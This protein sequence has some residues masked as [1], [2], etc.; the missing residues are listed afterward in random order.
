MSV[1]IA[2][3][4]PACGHATEGRLRP[5][6]PSCGHIVY[7][8]PK[9]AAITFIM[10][11]DKVLLVQRG[12]EPGMGLWAL[13][14]GYVDYDEHPAEAAMR[15]TYEETGLRIAVERVLDVFHHVKDGGVI[16]IAFAAGL[17]GGELCAGDDAQQIGWFS[18]DDLPELV[19]TSTISLVSRWVTGE[20]R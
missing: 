9:V 7:F 10:Q 15:E 16:T 1:Y 3:Y 8:D 2:D 11:D 20:I 13:P 4:C 17:V 14:G 19:F 6:C 5:V 12:I 18:K